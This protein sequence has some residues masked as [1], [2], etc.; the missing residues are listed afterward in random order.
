MLKCRISG[1]PNWARFEL[2]GVE[3]VQRWGRASCP[4]IHTM[5]LLLLPAGRK[6]TGSIDVG[7]EGGLIKTCPFE[8]AV[9]YCSKLAAVAVRPCLSRFVDNLGVCAFV[10]TSNT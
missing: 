5:L 10:L 7:T 4:N 8:I 9:D 3:M 1:G 2:P 6:H